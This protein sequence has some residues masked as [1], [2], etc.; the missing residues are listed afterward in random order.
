MK[1]QKARLIAVDGGENIE[2]MFN[3]NQLD[4]SRTISL[5]QAQGAR[6]DSGEN[7]TSFKHPNPYSLKISN[8]ILDTYET[9]KSVLEYVEKY[10]KAVEFSQ[11]GDGKDKRPPIY[12]FTWGKERYIRCFIKTLSF[13]LTLFLPDGTPVRAVLDLSLEQVD[14]P[15]PKPGQGA[16]NPSQNFREASGRQTF[17]R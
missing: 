3:P 2:F 11:G 15:T 13:K 8:I 7:K 10:T 6:T 4:F 17:L 14:A 5:E 12:L 1:L 16:T 9:G